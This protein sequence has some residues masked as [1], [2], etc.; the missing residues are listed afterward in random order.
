VGL[1]FAGGGNQ[2]FACPID[3]VLSRFD[4]DIL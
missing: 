1:L 3:K 4:I 2:T